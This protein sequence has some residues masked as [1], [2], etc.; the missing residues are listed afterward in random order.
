MILQR[1][2]ED[3]LAQASFLIGCP[4][5]HEAVVVDPNR[6]V[7]AYVRAAAAERLTIVAVTETHIHADFVSGA[8]ELAARTG[9]RLYVSSMGGPDWR[10]AFANEPG[11]VPLAHGDVIRVGLVKLEALHTPGHTPEHLSFRV[12][13]TAAAEESLGVLT[14][15]FVFAGDVGRPDLLER[16]AGVAGTMERSAHTLFASLQEFRRLPER[17]LLWPGHG[18]GSACG[19][20]L[21]GMP[22]TSLG[23]ERLVN[24]GLAATDERAFVR[25]ILEG[26]PD[27]PTYFARMKRLNR[28]GPPIL[29]TLAPPVAVAA[30]EIVQAIERGEQ[31]LDV[32]RSD[33]V[34]AGAIPGA[35]HVPAGSGFAGWAGWLVSGD[36]RVW[37]IADDAGT[38]AACAR[39]LRL[40]GVDDVAGFVLADEA[41]AAWAAKHGPPA[42]TPMT[43]ATEAAERVARGEVVVLD[44]RTRAEYAA[45]HVPRAVNV[46]VGRLPA[47]AAGLPSDRDVV[48]HCAGGSRS[49]IAISVLRRYGVSR[50]IEMPGGFGEHV[51]AGLPVEVGEAKHPAASSS[52]PS[53]RHP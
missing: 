40:I 13:D 35:L 3:A 12:T 52:T 31:V 25:D 45:G 32:R 47:E 37:L 34:A 7:E 50:V 51:R 20:S 36:A 28:D 33:R 43:S 22:V 4:I 9:A 27:P 29:G 15:D 53:S 18:P 49:P 8:R 42:R 23:Y 16:A 39:A 1:F 6:D 19:K 10:Y 17:L 11:V 30:T 21:G 46:P 48:V 14:G 2:Y 5:A 24:P 26:Q 38:A 44:V 41:L